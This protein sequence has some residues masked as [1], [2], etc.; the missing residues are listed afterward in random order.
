MPEWISFGKIRGSWAQVGNDLPIGITNLVDIIQAGGVLQAADTYNK[1]DLKP[2]I[3]SS[4]EFGTEW[5]FFHNRFGIDFTWYQTDTKNQL[6]RMPTAAGD[7]YAFR[8]INAGKIRN[9]GIELTVDATPVMND[10]FRWKTA[11]NFS[12]NSN[13]VVSLHPDYTSFT[14]GSTGLSMGYLMR[15]TEGG[16]LGDIYGN[17]FQRENGK[18]KLNKDGSPVVKTGNN[19]LLGNANPDFLLGWSNTFSYKGFSLY[20][21]IDARVG[22]D[23]MSLTQAILDQNGV[24]KTTAEARDRG[25]V[26]YE[27]TRF[28]GAEQVKGFFKSVGGR[29]GISEYYMYDATNIRLRELSIGYS[30]PQSLLEKTKAFKGI[31][32]SLVARNLFFIYKDAPFDPDATLSVGN[33]LQGVDVFGMPST[34]NIGFNIKFTF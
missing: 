4:I 3:S 32:V 16:S 23:V 31:D 34:R 20:F 25:Y 29:N 27:G 12:T 15:I 24:T 6:L 7:K 1:G 2:E 33:G 21:L 11:V 28:E 13:E 22:G 17:A 10:N 19:D 8:Y 14:Y 30:F 26:E 5:R 9:K 18:I